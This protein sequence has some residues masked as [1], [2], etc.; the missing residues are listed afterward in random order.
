MIPVTLCGGFSET[1]PFNFKSFHVKVAKTVKLRD[2]TENLDYRSLNS[3]QGNTLSGRSPALVKFFD[4]RLQISQRLA[5]QH[6]VG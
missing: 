5:G 4:F 6:L 1:L 2:K 3:W